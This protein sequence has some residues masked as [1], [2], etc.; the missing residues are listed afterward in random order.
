MVAMAQTNSFS[1]FDFGQSLDDA[2]FDPWFL[3]A[4]N[5]MP[6]FENTL[7]G[8]LGNQSNI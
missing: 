7:G 1:T 4:A 5:D 6:T 3:A 8:F 2:S